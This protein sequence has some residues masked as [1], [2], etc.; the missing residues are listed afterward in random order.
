MTSSPLN[1]LLQFVFRKPY[2][3]HSPFL[4]NLASQCIYNDK[5]RDVFSAIE[6]RRNLF[7]QRKETILVTDFG[8]GPRM[9]KGSM[10][11]QEGSMLV[12][13]SLASIVSRSLQ[14]PRYAR[15]FFRLV[16]HFQPSSILEMGTSLGITTAYLAAAN[17]TARVH[18]IEG[19][20][21]LASLANETFNELAMSNVLLTVGSF[22]QVLP[23]VL[24]DSP[25]WDMVYLDGNHSYQGVL[26]TMEAINPHIG[27]ASF[28]IVDDIRWSRGMWRAWKTLLTIPE[29]S[30]S[31]DLGRMGLL[32]FNKDLSK[33]NVMLGF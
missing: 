28:V 21:R 29:V 1:L 8:R 25:S 33:Q 32:F 11:S 16:Q 4:Y 9:R 10:V 5:Q 12:E 3:I 24:T 6:N 19:C 30:L 27:P 2:G 7:K 22:S 13:R 20:P 14:T 15:L 26:E 18:T 17:P 23:K 31:I